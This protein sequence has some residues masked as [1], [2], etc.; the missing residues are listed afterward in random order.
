M[1]VSPSRQRADVGSTASLRCDV[2]G[3]P[4]GRVFWVRDGEQEVA[5]GNRV[6][7]KEDF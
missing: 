6:R 1:R 7:T 5:S 2:T 3:G 4:V